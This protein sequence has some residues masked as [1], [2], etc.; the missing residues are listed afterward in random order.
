MRTD[1]RILSLLLAVLLLAAVPIQAFAEEAA[2]SNSSYCEPVTDVTGVAIP[3]EEAASSNSGHCEPVTDVTGVAI[4]TDEE[5][6]S[7]ESLHSLKTAPATKSATVT[8]S[9]TC[10]DNLTWELTDDGTLTISGTGAMTNYSYSS[11]PWYSNCSSIT[12]VIINNGVT[13]IGNNAFYGCSSLTDITIPDSVTSIGIFAFGCCSSLTDITIPDSVTSI[14]NGAFSLCS[15]LTSITIPDGVTSIGNYTF[16]CCSSLTAITIPD[17]VTSIGYNAFYFCDSL[18]SITIPDSVTSIGGGAFDYCDRLTSIT[19]EGA[20]PPA[21]GSGVFYNVTAT[22]YYPAGE[23]WTEDVRQNYGGTLTWVPHCNHTNTNTNTVE[24][25]CMQ[26]GSVTISC[27]DCG[28]TV[29]TEIIPVTDH[30]EIADLAVAPDCTNTGLTEGSHCEICGEIIIVQ[31]T[32]EALGHNYIDGTCINCGDVLFTV[33]A[34]GTCGDNLTWELTDDGTLTISGTGAMTNY[35]YDS[36]PWFSNRFS[37]TKVIINNGVTSIGDYAFFYCENLTSIIIPD[38]VTI[39]GNSA[40]YECYMTSIT[41]PDSVTSIGNE[42]FYFC[43]R[44]TSITI[45]DGVTS[46]GNYT[47]YFCNSLTSITI[48]DS[49]TSIGNDAFCCCSNLSNITIPD[50]VTSIGDGAFYGCTCLTSITIPDGVTSIGESAFGCCYILTSITIPDSVT[51]IGDYAFYHCESLTN[52][53]IPDSVTSIGYYA[54]NNCES[55]TSITFEGAIPPAFDTDVFWGVT[56]TVY[57]P[58]SELWTED[59]RQNYG[60]N[61]MWESYSRNV[62]QIALASLTLGNILKLNITVELNGLSAEEHL[63]S[64]TIGEDTECRTFSIGE[65]ALLP[66]HRLNEAV[67]I[68]L[69]H[70]GQVVDTEIWTWE[71]YSASLRQD[72]ADDTKM[73]ALLDSLSHYGSY[74][75]YYAKPGSNAPVN[76]AVD[77]VKKADL[78]DHQFSILTN[79]R[80]LRAVTSLYLDD[81][82]DLLVKFNASAW[83]DYTLYIDG[84]AVQTETVDGKVIYTIAELLPQDWSKQYNIK[85]LDGNGNTVYE[86]NYSVMSY[87]YAALNRQQEVKTGLNGLLKSMYLYCQA[88]QNYQAS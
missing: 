29:S 51:S 31:E 8:A 7:F 15:R 61:L 28:E 23:L 78:A 42:A 88:A 11:D 81:A 53:T 37:I 73:M 75:E 71:N 17:S 44:L 6:V 32:V 66:A 76:S 70:N 26:V 18:T 38:S 68:E 49:V 2:S 35:S 41:I 36:A 39:I 85:V 48:P 64:V 65:S 43:D 45:P 14:G 3:T 62:A 80:D 10:G 33:I 5:D 27:A 82:C 74:A 9:G 59:V 21:C 58:A 77:A 55:L 69:V 30:T 40:F 67:K 4:P 16:D 87:A 25:N 50:S 46:I 86:V 57:Y 56:A 47:F 13:S 54:F 12:K 84:V 83:G 72:H 24:A 20:I 60:G 79:H 34:S 1:K 22:A 63:L 19:F 52:I